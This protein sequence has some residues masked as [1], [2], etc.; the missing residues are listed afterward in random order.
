MD[1]TLSYNRNH[2]FFK[3]MTWCL[4]SNIWCF[5]HPPNP[6]SF[7]Y[8][9][10]IF[11]ITFWTFGKK[12]AIPISYQ[13]ISITHQGQPSANKKWICHPLDLGNFL[14]AQNLNFFC[15]LLSKKNTFLASIWSC[16]ENCCN[17]SDL[18][19]KRIESGK[20]WRSNED[21]FVDV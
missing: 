17:S 21:T 12:L 1:F 10:D 20:A 7:S 18:K 8:L 4:P 3:K 6:N 9:L 16:H 19:T 15:L 5:F 13:L 11:F 14:G 2:W